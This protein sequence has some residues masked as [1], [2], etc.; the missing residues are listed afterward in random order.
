MLLVANI[1]ERYREILGGLD[2]KARHPD[3]D[4]SAGQYVCHVADN[5]RIFGERLAA[6][7]LGAK[8]PLASYDQE[9]LARVRH[10][11]E[12][13]LPAALWSLDRSASDWVAGAEM[14]DPNAVVE[15]R[16]RGPQSVLDLMRASAHDAYH[17]GWDLQR[18]AAGV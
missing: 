12:I 17:H 13:T 11:E 5:L 6:I 10:Y 1:A 3:L 2:A 18:I 9:E 4:W 16:S 15:H 7:A 8:G 14:A